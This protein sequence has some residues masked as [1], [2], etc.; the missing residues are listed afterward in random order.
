MLRH[1]TYSHSCGITRQQPGAAGRCRLSRGRSVPARGKMFSQ[2]PRGVADT[3]VEAHDRKSAAPFLWTKLKYIPAGMEINIGAA[4]TIAPCPSI[5]FTYHAV[6][7]RH[8]T[9]LPGATIIWLDIIT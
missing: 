4:E 5:N 9:A 3:K 7:S 2:M 6:T 1:L 8:A